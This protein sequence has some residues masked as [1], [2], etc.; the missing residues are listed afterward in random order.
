MENQENEQSLRDEIEALKLIIAE[1]NA[2]A[3]WRIKLGN[4][5]SRAVENVI[6]DLPTTGTGVL[7]AGTIVYSQWPNVEP[8][9]I[10]EALG[11]GL[12]GGISTSKGK[13]NN[14]THQ[15]FG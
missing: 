10:A 1:K 6:D 14:V 11:F 13:V 9:A 3:P 12:L 8:Q 5:F 7:V 15:E 4:A 2:P